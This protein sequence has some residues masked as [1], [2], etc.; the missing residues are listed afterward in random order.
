ASSDAPLSMVVCPS[1][2]VNSTDLVAILSLSSCI[3]RSSSSSA[4]SDMVSGRDAAWGPME[5]AP[6][7]IALTLLPCG[8]LSWSGS[9]YTG[10]EPG[11]TDNAVTLGP[12]AGQ[13]RAYHL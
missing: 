10:F 5:C 1:A 3:I 6:D 9:I 2:S 11:E 7:S 8:E 4:C 13:K 12:P